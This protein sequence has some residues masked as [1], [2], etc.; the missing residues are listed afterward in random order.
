MTEDGQYYIHDKRNKTGVFYTAVILEQG[1][2]ILKKYN[3]KLTILGNHKLNVYLKAIRDLCGIDKPIF[4]HVA[5]QIRYRFS[6]DLHQIARVIGV[7]YDTAI[8]LL[9]T[10]EL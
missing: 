6:S 7:S 5:R 1:V 10:V 2:E 9:E 3:F 4:S 8:K